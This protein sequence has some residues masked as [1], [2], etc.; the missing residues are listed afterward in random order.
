MWKLEKHRE[1]AKRL[2]KSLPKP[3]ETDHIGLA[4]AS[5]PAVKARPP[6]RRTLLAVGFAVLLSMLLAPHGGK[7]GVDGFGPFFLREG[8]TKTSG[9]GIFYGTIGRVMMDMLALQIV[10]LAVLFAVCV[11]L[12]KSWRVKPK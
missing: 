1:L 7:Y 2:E 11:N 12:R 6:M 3:P 9:T 5:P 8:F 4:S 10:F